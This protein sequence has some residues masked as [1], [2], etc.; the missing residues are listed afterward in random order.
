[1]ACYHLLSMFS[2][3]DTK[4]AEYAATML[5]KNEGTVQRWRNAVVWNDGV[6][7][8]SKHGQ[9]QRSGMLWR[10]EELIRKQGGTFGQMHM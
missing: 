9:H 7:L 4:A 5:N 3:T 6:M 1:M 8:E 2:F 10:N